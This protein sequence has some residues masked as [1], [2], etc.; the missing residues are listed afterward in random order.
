LEEAVM[1]DEKFLALLEVAAQLVDQVREAWQEAL[2]QDGYSHQEIITS[3]DTAPDELLLSAIRDRISLRHGRRITESLFA[4][5]G[6]Q[7]KAAEAKLR[8]HTLAA[9]Y[10]ANGKPEVRQFAR[11][12]AEH[13]LTKDADSNN[14]VA[15]PERIATSM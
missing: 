2:A 1:A 6:P 10:G 8:L 14:R 4:K 7:S 5:L 3:L 13:G 9:L 11:E 15:K 12:L